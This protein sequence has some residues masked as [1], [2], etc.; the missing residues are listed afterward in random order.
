M[1]LAIAIASNLLAQIVSTHGAGVPEIRTAFCWLA[2][3]PLMIFINNIFGTQILLGMGFKRQYRNAVLFSGL[4]IPLLGLTLPHLFGFSGYP[5]AL[6]SGE[7]T[8]ALA[9]FVLA[10]KHTDWEWSNGVA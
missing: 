5:M 2:F 4:M 9:T 3:I 6:F 8:L 10:N 7:L 1:G